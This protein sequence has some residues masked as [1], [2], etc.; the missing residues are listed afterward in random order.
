MATAITGMAELG[1]AGA[2]G[3]S[4]GIAALVRLLTWTSPAFPVGAFAFSHGLEAVIAEGRVRDGEAL[5]GWIETLLLHG[6]GWNDLVFLTE[7]H[8]LA[9]QGE[10]GPGWDDLVALARASAGSAERR[11]EVMDLGRAFAEAAAPWAEP[12]Q[13]GAAPVPYTLAFGALAAREGV[14]LL[15]C[16]AA[17]AHAFAANLA[18]VA[19]RLVPLGQREAVRVIRRLEPVVGSAARRAAGSTLDDLGSA[20]ILSD[21]AALRHETLQPRLFL[22]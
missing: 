10:T 9:S 11:R 2:S 21:I 5:F 19:V 15:P 4:A 16:L 3:E 13:P 8:R 17:F 18:S 22:T 6:S 20:A 7:A 1:P 12:L 14:P